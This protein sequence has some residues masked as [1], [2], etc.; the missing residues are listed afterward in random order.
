MPTRIYI[1]MSNLETA[2]KYYFIKVL[3][4]YTLTISVLVNLANGHLVR[5]VFYEKNFRETKYELAIDLV[6]LLKWPQFLFLDLAARICEIEKLD[7]LNFKLC[8]LNFLIT[9]SSP[10]DF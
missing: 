8:S 5:C 6:W 3:T 4:W 2:L 1:Y 10:L 9:K 7:F